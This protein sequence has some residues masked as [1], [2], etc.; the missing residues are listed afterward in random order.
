MYPPLCF[1]ENAKGAVAEQAL[2]EAVSP[3]TGAVVSEENI[4]LKPA[5][6]CVDLW[7]ALKEKSGFCKNG[8]TF[9]K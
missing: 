7:Q 8:L 3:V 1:T 4:V 9:G 2:Q 5:L 6:K